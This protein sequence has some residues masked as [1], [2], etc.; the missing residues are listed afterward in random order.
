MTKEIQE[1]TLN[2]S[3]KTLITVGTVLFLM[4]GEYLVLQEDIS[5][6]KKKPVPEITK[7]EFDFNNDKINKLIELNT[8][9]INNLKE[10]IKILKK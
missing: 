8:I 6:A 3:V 1:T 5:E 4:V 7:L 9:E 2:I 10:E